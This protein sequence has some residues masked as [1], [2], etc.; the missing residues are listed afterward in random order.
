MAITR[1]DIKKQIDKLHEEIA[2]V[3]EN[4]PRK[5][6]DEQYLNLTVA[7]LAQ[8]KSDIEAFENNHKLREKR[9]ELANLARAH[10]AM[11]G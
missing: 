4:S 7:Q 3:E 2:W 9:V 6:R 5:E 1:E 11:K 10:S 8:Y